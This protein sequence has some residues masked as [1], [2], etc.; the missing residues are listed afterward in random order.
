MS[1]LSHCENGKEV[2]ESKCVHDLFFYS[3]SLS[4]SATWSRKQVSNYS[5]LCELSLP[6]SPDLSPPVHLLSRRNVIRAKIW[7]H[8][9]ICYPYWKIIIKEHKTKPLHPINHI[10]LY[11]PTF[12]LKIWLKHIVCQ[13][14]KTHMLSSNELCQ[15]L[16]FIK[17]H[18]D[19]R[20]HMAL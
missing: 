12:F 4:W 7:H 13:I 20:D 6:S 3:V 14:R 2:T 5:S 10:M 15:I 19:L 11:I 8:P 1:Q 18:P 16:H 9:Q 17:V